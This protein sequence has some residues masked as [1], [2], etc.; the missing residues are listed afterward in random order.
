MFFDSKVGDVYKYYGDSIY[1]YKVAAINKDPKIPIWTLEII[2]VNSGG[3]M[4][5]VG[6]KFSYFY[7]KDCE[8]SWTKIGPP[9]KIDIPNN[10][11][12]SKLFI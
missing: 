11:K 4:Y 1:T 5:R 8:R 12:Y 9:P 3:S 10:P 2:E 7:Y 6:D